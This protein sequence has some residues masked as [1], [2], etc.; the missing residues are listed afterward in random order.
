LLS[1]LCSK[2]IEIALQ[3]FHLCQAQNGMV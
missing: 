2:S 3:F 1:H